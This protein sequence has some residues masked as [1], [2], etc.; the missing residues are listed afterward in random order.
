MPVG[1]LYSIKQKDNESTEAFLNRFVREEMNVEDQN[2]SIA[3]GA[4]MAGL[5][6]E[7][8]LKYLISIKDDISYHELITEIHHHIQVERT[9]NLEAIKLNHD[10][11]LEGKCKLNSQASPSNKKTM[12]TLSSKCN[13][14]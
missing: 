10:I 9:S 7:T 8:V 3:C 4:L 11:L 2:D 1:H 14:D 13:H 6:N 12:K 5:R